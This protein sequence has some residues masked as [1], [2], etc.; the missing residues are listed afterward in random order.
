MEMLVDSGASNN[1][2]DEFAWEILNKRGVNCRSTTVHVNKQLFAYASEN[3]IPMKGSF[4]CDL[5]V[6][7]RKTTTEFLV[8]KGKDIPLLS[9]L[10]VLV[11]IWK[12]CKLVWMLQLFMT[13]KR[14]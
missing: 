13:S 6:G 9:N 2:V 10:N 1:T 3:P 5:M 11:W 4:T 8:I 7:K 14:T 12:H